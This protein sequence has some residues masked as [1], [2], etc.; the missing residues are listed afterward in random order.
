MQAQARWAEHASDYATF[1]A[2]M[3]PVTLVTEKML[4]KIQGDGR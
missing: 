1:L 4:R 3:H 2:A